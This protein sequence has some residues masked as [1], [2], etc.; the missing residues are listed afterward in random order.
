MP[1]ILHFVQYD[2]SYAMGIE[3]RFKA[4][5]QTLQSGI[6]PDSVSIAVSGYPA[7]LA[8]QTDA[9]GF[10][11]TAGW[12]FSFK[13][14]HLIKDCSHL[15]GVVMYKLRVPASHQPF[16]SIAFAN[17]AYSDQR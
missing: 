4:Y 10:Y 13:I 14:H 15:R 6:F 8:E 17:A 7:E 1:A 11:R 2:K 12:N 9:H 3:Q 16:K 5:P